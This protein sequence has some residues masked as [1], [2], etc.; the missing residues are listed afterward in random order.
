M[1]FAAERADWRNAVVYQIYPRSFCDSNGDGVGDLPGITSRLDYLQALGVQVVWLSPIYASPNDDNGYDISDYRQ[2][3][4]EFGTMADF[5]AMLAG[6]HVRGIRLMMDLVVNHTSDEHPWFVQARSSRSNPF[7]DHYIWADP[8]PDGSPPTNWEAA[9]QGSVWTW[10][11]PT[12]EYYLHM[13]SAKQPDLNWENPKV[14]Q[15]VHALMRF[16]LDKGVDGFRMDV[17]NMISKPWDAQGR[18]PQ[19]PV[20]R[21]GFLQPSFAMTCNGPR[22]NEFLRE[23]RNEVLDHYDTITVGEAPLAT[24]QQGRDIT[25]PQTGSL[26]ML[27]QFEHMDLDSV[28]G[29]VNGKWARKALDWRDMKACMARWQEALHGTGWNSLY[30]CN[31]DQPRSVSRFGTMGT[32]RERSAKALATWLHGMQGTPYIYQGEELG[33]GNVAFDRIEDYRDIET[34]NFYRVATARGQ[35][36]ADVMA[37][38]HAV[39]RDNARTPMPWNSGPHAGFSTGQPW[40]GLNPDCPQV[41]AEAAQADPNSVFHHYR[42]LIALRRQWPVLRDGRF[43]LLWAEDPQVCGYA[44]LGAEQTLLVVSNM[45]GQS[46]TAPWPEGVPFTQVHCLLSNLDPADHAWGRALHLQPFEALMLLCR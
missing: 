11:E 3:M 37:S 20:V 28:G 31:H 30:F 46:A 22:L 10:N 45:S 25:H 29:H 24:V 40:I 5:D 38:I 7:H 26:N 16:W 21:E 17:I 34:L 43:Q 13:F 41:N 14:R 23:M 9:F 1:H 12:G 8:L 44:R 6:M 19:A 32:L 18:L 2:I 15:E 4:A 35:S 27:F 39:G 36:H 42:Q 33:M